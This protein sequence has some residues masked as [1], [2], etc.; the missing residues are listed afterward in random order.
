[1]KHCS[2]SILY[3]ELPFLKRKLPFLY[4]HFDQIIFYDLNVKTFTYSNDGSH[5]FIKDFP[6]PDRKITLIERRNLSDVKT[7]YGVSFIPK[8]KMFAIGSRYVRDNIDVFWCTDMDEFFAESL[9]R[10]VDHAI[11]NTKAN[12]FLL[13][14]LVY[15]ANENWIFTEQNGT[16]FNLP[17]ARI[18]RHQKGNVYGHCSLSKQFKPVHTIDD[19]YL[20][21]FAYI[22]NERVKFKC[23]IYDKAEFLTK[24]WNRFDCKM[25]YPEGKVY[26][27]PDMHPGVKA[28]IMKSPY[29]I[30]KYIDVKQMVKEI[31]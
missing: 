23:N 11:T 18:A 30:P 29:K 10:K 8:R 19:E 26:G 21:H 3:N 16:P 1:M 7:Y 20:H 25:A 27:Y 9:I 28:G 31:R 13:Q 4:A 6:D 14:H 12:A 17:W 15:F 22:G 5:E 2:F 24:I